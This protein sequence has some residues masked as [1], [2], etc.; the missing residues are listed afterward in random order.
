ML[1]SQKREERMKQIA[2]I[3]EAAAHFQ[4]KAEKRRQTLLALSNRTS[5]HD[6]NMIKFVWEVDH[7]EL[8]AILHN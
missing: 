7:A 8:I 6:A 5:N 3:H 4:N 2:Q 1:P